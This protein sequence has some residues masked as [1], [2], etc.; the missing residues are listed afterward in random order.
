MGS[1]NLGLQDGFG[2]RNDQRISDIYNHTIWWLDVKAAGLFYQP[3]LEQWKDNF[4]MFTRVIERKLG[5]EAY[6][7][8]QFNNL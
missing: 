8:L 1:I 4:S 2:E 3:R 5:E 6:G 7:G